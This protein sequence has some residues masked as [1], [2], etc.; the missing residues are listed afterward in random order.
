MTA[1]RRRR[2]ASL[3]VA[4]VTL[5]VVM[6]IAAALARS[7]LLAHRQQQLEHNE[8]QAEWLA[9]SATTRATARLASQS[10]YRGET[11]IAE[12]EPA[13]SPDAPPLAGVA[14]IRVEKIE[15]R[16]QVRVIA[17]ARYPDHPWRRAVVRREYTLNLRPPSARPTEPENRP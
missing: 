4:L 16:P 2:G 14:E 13:S 1:N 8:L 11:W 3:V 10:D 12:V 15:S 5:M 17:V 6:L 7:M 9:E